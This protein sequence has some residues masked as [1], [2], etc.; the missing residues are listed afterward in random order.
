M[1][2]TEQ[3]DANYSL[4]KYIK[5]Q[6]KDTYH[7]LACGRTFESSQGWKQFGIL[8]A[9]TLSRRFR[10]LESILSPARV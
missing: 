2:Y 5:G 6:S 4:L 7:S 3:N 1:S 10:H 8:H 9:E